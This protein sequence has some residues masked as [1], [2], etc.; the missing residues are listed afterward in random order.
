[1]PGLSFFMLYVEG[2][3]APTFRHYSL[4]SASIEA[5]RLARVT[6]RKVHLLAQ[7]DSCQVGPVKWW[8]DMCRVH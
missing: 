6:G 8:S 1:M 5:E 3:G 4:S 7:V 2:A